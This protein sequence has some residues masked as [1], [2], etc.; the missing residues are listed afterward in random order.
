ML[1]N[2]PTTQLTVARRM[3]KTASCC[4]DAVVQHHEY[5]PNRLYA[6]TPE[7]RKSVRGGVVPICSVFR[8]RSRRDTSILV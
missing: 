7:P 8:L 4:K 5:V 2:H 3:L 1:K 6:A